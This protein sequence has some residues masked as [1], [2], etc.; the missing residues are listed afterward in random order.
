MDKQ[1]FIHVRK[2]NEYTK[3]SKGKKMWN[4]KIQH[5]SLR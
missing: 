5:I 2:K 3:N 4:F 1:D